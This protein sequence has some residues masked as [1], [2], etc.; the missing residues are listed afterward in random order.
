ML[1]P[2]EA[3]IYEKGK[4]ISTEL[5]G[6]ITVDEYDR[7]SLRSYKHYFNIAKYIAGERR[8]ELRIDGKEVMLLFEKVKYAYLGGKQ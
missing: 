6:N 7:V 1:K 4:K 5:L 8:Y 2:V 3:I